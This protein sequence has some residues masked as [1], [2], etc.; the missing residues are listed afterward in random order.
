MAEKRQIK[1]KEVLEDIR[2][3][4]SATEMMTKYKVSPKGLR[5][6]FR[7][8]MRARVISKPE[9]EDQSGL[10]EGADEIRGIRHLQRKRIDFRMKIYDGDNPFKT[11]F[12]RD[13]SEQG[14]RVEGI[15]TKLGETKNFVVSL[16]GISNLPTLVF[17]A[18]CRWVNREK[19][20][21]KNLL[22]GFQITDISTLD[23]RELRNLAL[24]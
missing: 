19:P 5:S 22:A 23:S 13:I 14:L 2:S 24:D 6:I 4:L 7:Q 10:Y 12:V 9:L 1:G 18:K 15:E 20:G 3:G 16:S 11:G 8:L 17:K 21:S